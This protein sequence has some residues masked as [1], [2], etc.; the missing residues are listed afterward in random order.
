MIMNLG[1]FVAGLLCAGA[2]AFAL[3]AW[4]MSTFCDNWW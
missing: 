4:V 2:L 3:T 1:F